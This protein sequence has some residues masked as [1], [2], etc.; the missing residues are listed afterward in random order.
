MSRGIYIT[1][2][3]RV[4]DQAIALI[5]SIRVYDETTPIVLIPY[6]ENYQTI[7]EILN[8][9]YGVTVYP[10]LALVDRLSHRLHQILAENSLPVRI[11]FANKPAGSASS[12]SF[13][14][15]TPI[16]SSSIKSSIT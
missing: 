4:L 3:D 16:S 14:I 10:D 9:R 11:S 7:A 13:C 8:Q 12:M 1:A 15:S 5:E 2:N 6:D